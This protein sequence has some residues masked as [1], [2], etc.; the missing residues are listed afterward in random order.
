MRQHVR[1]RALYHCSRMRSVSI[2]EIQRRVRS[3]RMHR[4]PDGVG[5]P[6]PRGAEPMLAFTG[7]QQGAMPQTLLRSRIQVPPVRLS[8]RHIHRHVSVRHI[9]VHPMQR[10]RTIHG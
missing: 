9:A 10:A 1:P 2:R 6:R 5:H 3:Q 8:N 7:R 4:M